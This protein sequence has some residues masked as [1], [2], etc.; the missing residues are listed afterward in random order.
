MSYF[1]TLILDPNS[2]EILWKDK[3]T[4]LLIVHRLFRNHNA[5]QRVI[6]GQVTYHSQSKVN[7]NEDP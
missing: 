2:G 5:L 4:A 6:G 1:S 3:W 7:R